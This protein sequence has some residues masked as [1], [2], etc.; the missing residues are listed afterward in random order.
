M[1]R[2]QL[3]YFLAIEDYIERKKHSPRYSDIAK[4]VGVRS[5][6]TVHKMVHYLAEEGYL[7]LDSRSGGIKRLAPE[8]QRRM[9]RCR[10]GHTQIWFAA[11]HCPMCPL[12][13][14]LH[15]APSIQQITYEQE[16]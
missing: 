9:N 1:T 10:K 14:R 13:L 15:P 16:T 7:I 2:I 12:L 3:R 4:I 6:A 8:Q 11:K 5:L